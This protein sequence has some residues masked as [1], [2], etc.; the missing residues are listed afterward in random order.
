MGEPLKQRLPTE[1]LHAITGSIRKEVKPVQIVLR[2]SLLGHVDLHT[3]MEILPLLSLY[4]LWEVAYFF[5]KIAS[6]NILI[7]FAFG[8]LN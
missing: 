3:G 6:S 2:Q 5:D 4:E 1:Q 7:I 8:T